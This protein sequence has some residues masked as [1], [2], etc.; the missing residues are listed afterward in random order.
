LKPG[1]PR[2]A[3][4]KRRTTDGTELAT[5][6]IIDS[7]HRV[8]VDAM[9]P[10]V[11]RA[12]LRFDIRSCVYAVALP[13]MRPVDRR[14]GRGRWPDSEAEASPRNAVDRIARDP[15]ITPGQAAKGNPLMSTPFPPW[16]LHWFR[17]DLRVAGNPALQ[18]NW[19]AH[20]GRVVGIFCFDSRFLSRPDFSHNRFGF[21]METLRELQK[22]MRSIGSDLWVIDG[23]PQEALPKIHAELKKHGR[24]FSSLS[25]NRD[26]EPFA[27]DRDDLL[28]RLVQED[29][30]VTVH[31]ERD[32]LLIEPLEIDKP[33]SSGSAFYQ[34]YS[35]FAKRWFEKLNTD[36]VRSR[37]AV[38]KKGLQYLQKRAAGEIDPHLF[39]LTWKG[40]WGDHPAPFRESL[41]D[42]A[43]KNRPHQ[44]I[45]IPPA[46]SLV[47]LER[48][49]SF[50][51]HVEQYGERR[52]IPS[53]DGTSKMSIYLKNGSITS[54]QII[55]ELGLEGLA[56]QGE[57]GSTK[58][59]KEIAWRE[60]YYSIL[61]H[62]PSVEKTAFIEKYGTL[63]WQND[64][65][66]FEAWKEG[67][68]GYPIVDAGMRQLKQEGWMHNRVRMIVA[69]FL[70]KDLLID[71]RWGENHFMKELLDGDLAPNNGGWQWAA[72]TGC[73]P[74][75]YFRIFNPELQGSRF[76]PEG[77]YVTRYIPE[78]EG[79]SPKVIHAPEKLGEAAL[80]KR[81]YPL[82]V[83]NHQEQKP[84]ALALF[85]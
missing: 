45:D 26:Y 31:T 46:G 43:E 59:L 67:R 55:A 16:G 60:F 74:Q 42:F 3:H 25:F 38:Q 40:V 62:K 56:F 28:T 58:Y 51:R 83:V 21:F 9:V 13:L 14:S 7:L 71:W 23:L 75:P 2:S 68:T 12:A 11:A 6:A 48:L 15:R 54:S 39:S 27:R 41:E 64:E 65:R 76:D 63:A 49:R 36:E 19:K 70:T 57:G 30:G 69:S 79:V 32:H 4:A 10:Q 22:E 85:K 77:K 52:D 73:D 5:R 18:W 82:P 44:T 29:L 35:P 50:K 17:R 84:K 34:V 37:I 81:R 72:S 33:A 61:F 47:A 66:L 24:A 20:G 53:V 80:R 78:L 1:A 8:D